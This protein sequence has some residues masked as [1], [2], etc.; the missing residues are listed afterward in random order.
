M[1]A[2]NIKDPKVAEKARKLAALKGKT[3]TAA[4]SEALDE[5]LDAAKR[6]SAAAREQRARKVDEILKRF[7]AVLPPGAPSYEEIMEE[8]YDEHG[9]PR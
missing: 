6:K 5:S 9:L 4:V 2:L 8:M 7:R 3:I 1:G